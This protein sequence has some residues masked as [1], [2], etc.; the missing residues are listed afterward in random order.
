[1]DLEIGIRISLAFLISYLIIS[2]LTLS[3]R[4][5]SDATI[6]AKRPAALRVPHRGRAAVP[7]SRPFGLRGLPASPARGRRLLSCDRG[8][9]AEPRAF[10]RPVH[11]PHAPSRQDDQPPGGPHAGRLGGTGGSR[12]RH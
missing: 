9:P 6:D 2:F 10:S 12:P 3:C 8:E 5:P 11:G 1:M 4:P 7:G